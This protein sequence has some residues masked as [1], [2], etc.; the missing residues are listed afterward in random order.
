VRSRHLTRNG[1]TPVFQIR[2]PKALDPALTLAPIRITLGCVPNSRARRIADV[3]GGLARIEF[4]RIENTPMNDATPA[5][6]RRQVEDRL[7]LV[8][9]TLLGLGVLGQSKLS[10]EIAPAA[11]DGV[12][13][14]LAEVG[15]KRVAG[16]RSAVRLRPEVPIVAALSDENTARG[17]LG[18]API[19][20]PPK[21]DPIMAELAVIREMIDGKK[22]PQGPLFSAAAQRFVA[23]RIETYGDPGHPEIGYLRHRSS[24]FLAVVGDKPV[25]A[26]DR[27]D[28]QHFA[29]ELSWLPPNVSKQEG[30]DLARVAE[31]V[32]ANKQAEGP[33]LAEKSIRETYLSRIKTILREACADAKVPVA[34]EGRIVIPKRA[35]PSKAR[36]A[37]D[38]EEFG[39]VV[40][41]GVASG[42]LSD[43]LLPALGQLTGRRLGLLVFMRRENI[44]RYNGVWV[45]RPQ[46]HQ[47]RDG[48]WEPVPFKTGESLGLFVLHDLFADCG[49]IEWALRSAGPVFPMLMRT[50]DPADAAQKRMKRLYV[51]SGADPQRSS[52]FHGLRVGKIRNDRD[53]A[54]P[55][56]AVRLQVGHELTDVHERYDGQMTDGELKTFATAP[57]PPGVD[58]SLLRKIDFGAFA[59]R[60]PKGGRPRRSS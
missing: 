2:V 58:W 45:Y 49:F 47:I 28:L 4:A 24:V 55:A 40:A 56:R 30:Y 57:L 31:Y 16:D 1:R 5:D 48:R 51:R 32:A 20:V 18:L 8:L 50:E 52:T 41:A 19:R 46:S 13:D 14:L 33:G 29:N 3:L 42:I 44:L 59:V 39:K 17:M 43:A 25:D 15:A 21:P 11:I 27:A 7:T 36:I 54:L 35:A 38:Q 22:G 9:P 34:F 10:H 26:Y 23:G 60:K 12:F 37:P 6:A 53:L